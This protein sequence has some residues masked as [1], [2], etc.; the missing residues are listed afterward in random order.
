[1]VGMEPFESKRVFA[2]EIINEVFLTIL[3]YHCFCFTEFMPSPLSQFYMGYSFLACL[4]SMIFINIYNLVVIVFKERERKNY[5]D[6]LKKT[7]MIKLKE[8]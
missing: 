7:K 1:M 5:L 4:G 6:K 8:Y 2:I 3:Y